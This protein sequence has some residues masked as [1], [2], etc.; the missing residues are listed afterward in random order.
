MPSA[1]L[2]LAPSRTCTSRSTTHTVSAEK[3]QLR[4]ISVEINWIGRELGRILEAWECALGGFMA[5]QEA[6]EVIK[7]ALR[8]H[9]PQA[10]QGR[11]H[12]S[13]SRRPIRSAHRAENAEK[14]CAWS[15]SRADDSPAGG[16]PRTKAASSR[17]KPA[18]RLGSTKNPQQT[19]EYRHP[20]CRPHWQ[21]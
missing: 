13:K 15:R 2:S 8:Q 5:D 14:S 10:E 18:Q 3:S 19:Q 16:L 7:C 11:W 6:F 9:Q 1:M 12:H 20:N 4:V 21:P 17:Q